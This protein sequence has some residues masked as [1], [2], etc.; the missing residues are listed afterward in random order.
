VRIINADTGEVLAQ[1]P[2][3]AAMDKMTELEKQTTSFNESE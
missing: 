1:Y 2:P 3:T